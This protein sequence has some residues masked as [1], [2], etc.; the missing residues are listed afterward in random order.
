MSKERSRGQKRSLVNKGRESSPVCERQGRVL[1]DSRRGTLENNL[2]N[3]TSGSSDGPSDSSAGRQQSTQREGKER[4]VRILKK[5]SGDEIQACDTKISDRMDEDVQM[6]DRQSPT[7]ESENEK[8]AKA[9]A[10]LLSDSPLNKSKKVVTALHTI[11]HKEGS[12]PCKNIESNVVLVR[13]FIKLILE[14]CKVEDLLDVVAQS[15]VVEKVIEVLRVVNPDPTERK[16][17]SGLEELERDI[18]FILGLMAIKVEHQQIICDSHALPTLVGIVRRYSAYE[19]DELIGIAA[20]TCRRASDAITNLAH[21]NN[22]VKNMVREEDGIKPLVFLLESVD[23]KVQRAVAGTLRTLAFKNEENKDLIV[24]LD[25]LPLLI[26]MLRSDDSSIHYEAV[27]VIGN[28]VHSSQHIKVKV[29]EE[30]ALQPVIDLLSSPCPDSQREAALLLGQFATVEADYKCKIVQRGA[31]PPLI[32]MLSSP[33]SQLKEM[34]AFA[35]GR[36]AQNPDN[37]AGIVAMG[38]LKP[39][40]S[41]LDS[42][43]AN[44]QHNAA[45]ALYGL[46]ENEDNLLHFIRDDAIRKIQEV[47]L[48]PQASRDCVQKMTRRLQDKL[49]D[50]VIGQIL[51]LFKAC[52]KERETIAI[53]LGLLCTSD[54]PVPDQAAIA[55]N[56]VKKGVHSMLANIIEDASVSQKRSETAAT[57]LANIARY[58]G[59]TATR[60]RDSAIQPPEPNIYLGEQYVGK[61]PLSDIVF[62]I[63]GKEF[64]AHK[65][66]LQANSEVFKSMFE[67]N[68]R[69]K[70][71]DTIPIPNIRWPVFE[72]MMR[73]MYTGSVQVEPGIAQELLEAA[74]QY[75]VD[76]L[77]KLCEEAI[78]QQLSPENVL[79][80]F[81]LAEAYDAPELATACAMYCLEG[82]ASLNFGNRRDYCTAMRKVTKKLIQLMESHLEHHTPG[83]AYLDR[84]GDLMEG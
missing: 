69:E 33:D 2:L 14:L 55:Y 65:I 67:G 1:T 52:T 74:D 53:N 39:L 76:H 46:S 47:T 25:A 32:I 50:Q 41:L 21:E 62:L 51:Y 23:S 80:A 42:D 31:V 54:Q 84:E 22:G 68:Y 82:H 83:E 61:K 16:K 19:R 10:S 77:K 7:V 63:E 6:E 37:Q 44:L 30:G 35:L 66:A 29:L 13:K 70:E 40:L 5:R 71:A 43:Q 24:E 72:A 36:L 81:D 18:T 78:A 27:G 8:R 17:V 73:C 60:E 28:L 11:L 57:A 15:G 45:F 12:T 20:Q 49:D 26:H 75:M 58:S 38:G 3:H 4:Q 79:A 56:F 34:A 9:L 59:V 64:Y 48:G